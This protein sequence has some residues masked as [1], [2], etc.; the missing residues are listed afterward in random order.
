MVRRAADQHMGG[1]A[2]VTYDSKHHHHEV[3]EDV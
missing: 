2:P 3:A 1:D